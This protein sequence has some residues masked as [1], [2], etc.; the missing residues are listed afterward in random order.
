MNTEHL[1][2]INDYLFE[3]PQGFKKGM[4]VPGRIYGSRTLIENMDTAVLEQLSNVAFLP[5]IV[6]H[7]LCMPDG[8]SGYGFPIGGVAAVDP[9]E[10][11]I[12]P[13]GIGFDINCGVRLMSTSLTRDE[14]KPK[15][16]KLIEA[17][18]TRIPSGVGS[19][20]LVSLSDDR[21][22]EAVRL[23]AE[24][25]VRNG[26]GVP[27]D[28][29]MIEEGGRIMDADPRAVS[30]KARARGKEQIGSLGSGNHY[31]EIQV[32]RKDDVFDADTA[33]TFG[34]DRDEQIMVMIHSGS[35]GYG[36]QIATDYLKRF[37]SV[38]ARRFGLSMP[39][40]ELACAPFR[41]EEGQEYFKAMNCAINYAFL[42]RQVI[43]HEVKNVFSDIFRKSHDDLGL[44]LV[45]DVCHN[46][47]KLEKHRMQGTERT[48]LVHRKG[49]TRAFGP[50]MEGIPAPYRKTGQPV[51]IGGSM[52]TGSYILAGVNTSGDAFHSTC[53]GSGRVMSRTRARSAYRGRDLQ[54]DLKDRG[55]LVLTTSYSGLAEE[56]GGAYKNV[57]EVIEATSRGGLSRA[58]AR[59]LPL[60]NIKG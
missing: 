42:N 18:F 16:K 57:D 36:H 23:G 17:L 15:L 5:G 13:G 56:A 53:H 33:G 26:H 19:G 9:D 46:T 27:G 48:M 31:L 50:G 34:I 12:S 11:V 32:V 52:E 55:I 10:G 20:G 8:H 3:L 6:G 4:R 21:F 49:A 24:W 47:A 25:A 41:S 22:D 7:A 60:A 38:M 45:Y 30:N 1:K 54:K 28:L 44:R 2:Q 35:R 39:D 14:L 40:R 58:V 29:E 43:M 37:L 51:L 59:L